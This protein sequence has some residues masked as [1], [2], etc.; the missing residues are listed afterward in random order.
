[1]LLK[2]LTITSREKI[3]REI[4]FHNGLN[5]IVD[6]SEQQITGNSVGKTTVLKLVD[7]CLGA[8]KKNIYV[9]PETKRSEYKLV[10]DFLI[11]H[12][13]LITLV[14]STDLD[15]SNAD[16]IVIE[17]NF[18]S[19]KKEGIRRINGQQILDENFEIEFGKIL[20]PT[21]LEDKPSFR[22]II[23]HNIRYKDEN[24]QNT[25]KTLDKWTSDAEY[26]T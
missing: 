17:R 18:L 22:Q 13:V 3:I 23:S 12:K 4:L 15:D 11:E 26:E 14:L 9:D 6:E 24:I 20:F 25:L 5:L 19:S 21:V 16:Q 8:D 10:K 7:F 1:M 2:S